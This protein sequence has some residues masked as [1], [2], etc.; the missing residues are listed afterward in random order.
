MFAESLQ[1]KMKASIKRLQ[2]FADRLWYGPFIGILAALDNF[3]VIIPNDGILISSAMLVPRRWFWF[4]LC[5]AIGSVIGASSLA[6]F[7]QYHGLPWVL[8]IFP[9]IDQT[10]T[11]TWTVKF[12]EE[13]GLLLVFAVAVT[14][15]VQQPAVIL[16]SL[17]G[18]SL[19][20]IALVIFVG[21]FIKFLA[22]AYVG[23][24][25]PKLLTKIWGMKDELQDVGIEIPKK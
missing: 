4:A 16:A 8:D 5:I 14:P 17:A 10:E 18:R 15:F 21:R 20:H 23:A 2:T 24:H 6:A 1:L 3:I 22:M 12:F 19:F 13:Y 25:T 9:G 11:W 7:T